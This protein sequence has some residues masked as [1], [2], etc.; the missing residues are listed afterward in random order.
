[1]DQGPIIKTNDVFFA[2]IDVALTYSEAGFSV[3]GR[4]KKEVSK[5]F[6]AIEPDISER[7]EGA[8]RTIFLNILHHLKDPEFNT[9]DGNTVNITV[10]DE[11]YQGEF[12]S[13]Y[14]G[15][16]KIFKVKLL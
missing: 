15:M 14:F 9:L 3:R 11:W 10:V 12:L 7:I 2:D 6:S 5:M 1:M 16:N 4:N 13:V 8:D